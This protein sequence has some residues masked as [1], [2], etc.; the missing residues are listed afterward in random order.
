VIEPPPVKKYGRIIKITAPTTQGIVED[1]V[2]FC[3][4]LLVIFKIP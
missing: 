1:K 2:L 3:I 4:E